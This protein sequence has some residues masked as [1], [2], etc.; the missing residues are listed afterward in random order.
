M[1]QEAHLQSC[2]G[3]GLKLAMSTMAKQLFKFLSAFRWVMLVFCF[4]LAAAL[5]GFAVVF[6]IKTV[7]FLTALS[8]MD[9]VDAVLR[10]LG[11]IDFALVAGL[12]VMV[13]LSTFSSFVE[14]QD[15][16][17]NQSWLSSISFGALKLK[18]ASTIAA[19]GG[20]NLLET[21]FETANMN[22]TNTLLSLG[23]ELVLLVI[24]VVFALVDRISH[25]PH[26]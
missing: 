16:D 26:A 11:L 14:N 25:K 24:V 18:L 9:E 17:H 3:Q 4:G 7:K 19:I 22:S 10:I 8:A 21:L 23:I 20:I 12:I 2:R 6:T 5:C 13:M 1:G 15:D